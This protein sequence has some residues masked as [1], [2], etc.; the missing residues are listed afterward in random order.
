M[1]YVGKNTVAPNNVINTGIEQVQS[2]YAQVDTTAVDYIKNKPTLASVATSGDYSDLSNAPTIP[3]VND[4]TLTITQNGTSVWTFTANA[5]SDVTVNLTDTTYTSFVGADGSTAGSSGLVPAPGA[6]DNIKYLKGDGNFS[7]VAYSEI[8][9]TPTIPTVNNGTLMISQN[10]VLKGVFTANSS[11]DVDVLLENLP[12]DFIN[13]QNSAQTA[14]TP[15]KVWEGTS[16]DYADQIS[17]TG[18]FYAWDMSSGGWTG[19]T[20]E[21]PITN[22][23]VI[24]WYS[25]GEYGPTG[26]SIIYTDGTAVFVRDDYEEFHYAPEKNI[27]GSNIG[28]DT[29]CFVEGEGIKR[30]GVDIATVA[31]TPSI[32]NT[33]ITKNSSDKLQASAVMNARTGTD[34]LPIWQGTEQ[35]W[36]NG[37][38][39]DWYNWK[40]DVT[41]SV[42]YT[43]HSTYREWRSIAYGNG[44]Y[45]VVASGPTNT[46]LRKTSDSSWS[47][48]TFDNSYSIS[49]VCYGDGK[50]IAPIY[51]TNKLIYSIDDGLT[52]TEIT[53]SQTKDW[54]KSLYANGKFIIS[55]NQINGIILY[56]NDGISW[57]EASVPVNYAGG[58]GYGNGRYVLTPY[59]SGSGAYS[60]D[61]INWTAATGPTFNN[62][63][64]VAYGNGKFVATGTD[65]MSNKVLYSE[66]GEVWS[67]NNNTMPSSQYWKN[68]SFNDGLFFAIYGTSNGAAYIYSTD[69]INWSNTNSLQALSWTGICYNN[70]T[71]TAVAYSA[72]NVANI[73]LSQSQCYTLEAEPTTSSTVY[74]EPNTTSALTITSI[75]TGTITLSD[76]NTYTYT[77]SGD[78]TTYQTIGDVYPNWLCNINGVGVKVGNTLVA[79]ATDTSGLQQLLTAGT[80]ID[81]TNNTI[82][83]TSPTLI[84]KSTGNNS[85]N[86]DGFSYYNYDRSVNI[87]KDSYT[88]SY[89]SVALG[90]YANAGQYGTA[91]GY[92]TAASGTSAIAIGTQ[93]GTSSTSS[94]VMQFGKGTNNESNTVKFGNGTNNWTLLDLTTGLIPDARLSSNVQTTSNLVTSVSSSSTDTQYPSA[95]LFYDTVGNIE[96]TL[97]AIIAQGSNS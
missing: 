3:T 90:A 27:A 40:T 17:S 74:S 77:S 34:A 21:Y 13:N 68:I 82:S 56:S 45:I 35:Q 48:L 79:N 28:P 20:M 87:G 12:A 14:T 75:G 24:Y 78:V 61:G 71:Y 41:G 60:D 6:S 67:S 70:G 36:T 16:S 69:G 32:D 55:A 97:D 85:L 83:V 31:T 53:L 81:I 49:T 62:V 2:D 76:N 25:A 10:G 88:T 92:G 9:G 86:I 1:L 47:T 26:N 95:K 19:Y 66:D 51:G 52:W 59:S 73:T 93:A 5:S 22:S 63:Q 42:S 11:T 54:T 80:G 91:L 23:S 30:N 94:N 18:T 37:K 38:A 44:V 57:S 15:L 33:T 64:V 46:Y 58:L 89:N 84:N 29:I 96:A 50:F 4:A 39:T 65:T 72:P 8:S 7:Q 43:D